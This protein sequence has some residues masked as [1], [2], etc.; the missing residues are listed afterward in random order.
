MGKSNQP[1]L[2]L[3]E[4]KAFVCKIGNPNLDVGTEIKASKPERLNAH[5]FVYSS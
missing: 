5:S 4:M 2:Q 1:R 3:L